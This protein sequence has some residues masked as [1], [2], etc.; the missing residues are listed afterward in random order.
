MSDA[1]KRNLAVPFLHSLS[2]NSFPVQEKT[3]VLI[4]KFA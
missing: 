4:A 3:L 1:H 2:S